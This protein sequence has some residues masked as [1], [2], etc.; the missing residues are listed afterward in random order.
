MLNRTA[1]LA[2]PNF[3]VRGSTPPTQALQVMLSSLAVLQGQLADAAQIG[4]AVRSDIKTLCHQLE[5]VMKRVRRELKGAAAI[6]A[7][8]TTVEAENITEAQ[9]AELFNVTIRTLRRW[10]QANTGFPKAFRIGKKK[11]RNAAAVRLWQRQQELTA[12]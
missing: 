11:F 7:H 6:E 1:V 4:D 12:A 5:T 8:D 10:D 2:H 3:R 9:V